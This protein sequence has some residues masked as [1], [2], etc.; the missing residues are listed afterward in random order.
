MSSRPISRRRAMGLAA[1]GAVGVA[2]GAAG[3]V[4]SAGSPDAGFRPAVSGAP[5]RDPEVLGSR[6]GRLHVELTAAAGVRL[7]GRDTAALG[8]N[9]TSPGPTLRVRPGDELSVRLTNRLKQPT[10]LHTH[11][12]RVS[13]QGNG[14]NPFLRIEPGTSFDYLLRIPPGHPAGTFWYHPHHHGMVADQLFGGLAGMLL[15]DGGPD[16]PVDR[17]RVLL[18]TDTTMDAGGGVAQPG[19]MDRMRGR[20]GELVLVNGQH[21]PSISAAPG[22]AQRW[23]IVNGCVSRMLPLRLTG[24]ALDLVAL[25]GAFLPAPAS[26]DR[27]ALAPGNRADVVVRPTAAGRFELVSEASDR[28]STGVGGDV[29]SEPVVLAT[30]LSAGPAAPVA[31]LPA[32][33]P[34][35]NP[36]SAT[37][38]QRQ[39]AFTMGMG[40][41]GMTFGIDGRAFDPERDDHSVLFGT[42]EEWTVTSST[43]M[44]HPFH[45]HVWPF[46]VLATSDG[47][48]LSGTPQDVVLVPPRGWVRLRIPFTAH[49]GRSVFHCHILDHEDAGMMATIQVRR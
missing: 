28:G 34:A 40:M 19:R 24:H 35:E 2:G 45:L 12:L 39:V 20:Q 36:G 15:V 33:L 27:V 6:G 22:T 13:P 8:F 49:T 44:A 4:W 26:R 29:R 23:R 32:A 7:A 31:P 21:Q 3:W 25:D 11:G 10:N 47:A 48:P 41:G 43:P 9:G 18:V 38:A 42:T 5:L 46:V 37:E 16:L 1:A 14:D 30:L 17:D